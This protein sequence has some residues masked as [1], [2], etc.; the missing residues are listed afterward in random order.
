MDFPDSWW[1]KHEHACYLD[2]LC[3]PHVPPP[4]PSFKFTQLIHL[5][6]SGS[7]FPITDDF[8]RLLPSRC[9]KTLNA[10]DCYLDPEGVDFSG[11]CTLMH[12]ELSRCH[13]GEGYGSYV[14][15]ASACYVGLA[16]NGITDVSR[17]KVCAARQWINLSRNPIQNIHQLDLSSCRGVRLTLNGVGGPNLRGW[18]PADNVRFVSMQSNGLE[19]LPDFACHGKLMQVNVSHNPITDILSLCTPRPGRFNADVLCP[20]NFGNCPL[21][22]QS[23]GLIDRLRFLDD[24]TI[25]ERAITIPQMMLLVVHRVGGLPEELWRFMRSYLI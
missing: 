5:S 17:I 6:L 25:Q 2:L 15:P 4:S 12:V 13:A 3:G 7:G 14:F 20:F 1:K 21:D 9:F 22:A 16:D 23:R 24:D 18:T 10:D 8:V 19:K 11:L